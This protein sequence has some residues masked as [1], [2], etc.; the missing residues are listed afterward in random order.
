MIDGL[1]LTFKFSAM[2]AVLYQPL[3]R[4]MGFLASTF[5]LPMVTRT[6]RESRERPKHFA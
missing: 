3:M 5:W 4:V 1:F 2:Q 6:A